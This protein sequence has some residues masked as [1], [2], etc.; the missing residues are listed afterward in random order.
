[1]K[2]LEIGS[3]KS[4]RLDIRKSIYRGTIESIYTD[5]ESWSI[6][7]FCGILVTFIAVISREFLHRGR[8]IFQK[9]FGKALISDIFCILEKKQ[10]LKK[11]ILT[12][13]LTLSI[14]IIVVYSRR[15]IARGKSPLFFIKSMC[16]IEKLSYLLDISTPLP[17]S[18]KC[19]IDNTMP[20]IDITGFRST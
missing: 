1:M 5:S 13:R 11:A 10:V 20:D 4:R 6:G 17:G 2:T 16:L 18:P 8:E 12:Q 19:R 14:S 9:I 7:D 3:D 15:G